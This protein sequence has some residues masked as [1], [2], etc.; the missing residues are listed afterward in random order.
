MNA[1][2]RQRTPATLA[3]VV[4]GTVNCVALVAGATGVHLWPHQPDPPGSI[5]LPEMVGVQIVAGA[6]LFPMAMRGSAAVVVNLALVV[7]MQLLAATLSAAPPHVVARTAPF[8]T[9]WLLGLAGWAKLAKGD[10]MRSC[11]TA[12]ALLLTLG[13][14]LLWYVSAETAAQT[15][16]PAPLPQYFGPLLAAVSAS[17]L[18]QRSTGMGWALVSMPIVTSIPLLAW[19]TGRSTLISP[20]QIPTPTS[21]T[22][23]VG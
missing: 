14:V 21:T 10:L 22:P 13:G 7:P 15:G 20:P 18:P 16:R 3:V 5:A 6:A 9:L 2:P 11:L 23:E 4:W 1:P 17:V 8:T 19:A 12:V